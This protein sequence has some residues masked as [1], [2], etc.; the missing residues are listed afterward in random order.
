M[1]HVF[2]QRYRFTS[3]QTTDS[4]DE[5]LKTDDVSAS[6]NRVAL[7][8][9][10]ILALINE[11]EI[12]SSTQYLYNII[13]TNFSVEQFGFVCEVIRDIDYVGIYFRCGLDR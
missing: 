13:T 11:S 4:V 1:V 5:S 8:K 2:P 3:F 7:S 6:T 10:E 9:S 12:E